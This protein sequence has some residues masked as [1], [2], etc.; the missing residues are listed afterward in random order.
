[1]LI[2]YIDKVWW[3]RMNNERTMYNNDQVWKVDNI[4]TKHTE[5]GKFTKTTCNV[6]SHHVEDHVAVGLL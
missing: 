6:D 3:L 1:M 5:R 4:P 2:I